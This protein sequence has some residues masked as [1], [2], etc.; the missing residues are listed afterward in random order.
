V[1]DAATHPR[2]NAMRMVVPV[3]AAAWLSRAWYTF[4]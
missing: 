3:V 2:S 4:K 1:I